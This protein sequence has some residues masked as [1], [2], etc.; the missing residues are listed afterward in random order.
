METSIF[1]SHP[2]KEVF[3]KLTGRFIWPIL[4]FMCENDDWMTWKF[5]VSWWLVVC[6]KKNFANFLRHPSVW[7][8]YFSNSIH[9]MTTLLRILTRHITQVFH[10]CCRGRSPMAIILV[11]LAYNW[12]MVNMT[13]KICLRFKTENYWKSQSTIF[14]WFVHKTSQSV[15]IY[16]RIIEVSPEIF[17]L[18]FFQILNHHK[19]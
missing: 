10:L 15:K 2:Y 4:Y 12:N 5:P 7:C 17:Y 18:C 6:V 3:L 8:L 1:V 13:R 16:A 14:P 11:F 9:D 19:I